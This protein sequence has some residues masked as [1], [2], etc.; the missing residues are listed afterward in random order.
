MSQIER[1]RER[2]AANDPVREVEGADAPGADSAAVRAEGRA[3]LD[4]AGAAI[5]RA[6]SRDSREFLAQSRQQGGQ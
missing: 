4:A 1:E 2:V 5:D 6:L 3:L